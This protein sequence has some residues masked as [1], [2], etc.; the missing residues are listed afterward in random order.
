MNLTQV[1]MYARVSSEQQAETHTIASQVAALRERVAADGLA[2]SE[3]M[4][5]LDE[6]YSGATLVRPALERLRDVIAAGSV[7][8]LY[9]HSP[10]RL[11]RKYAYQVLLVD[12]FRRA[13]VEVVFLNRALGQSPEDDLLLQVQGMIAE[14]ERAK[15]IE[16]HR[17]GK[18]HAA[19]IGTVN[20]LSGAP[21]G[22]R[23]V[24]KYEGGGQARYEIV[25][26]EARVV[27]QVFAWVGHD[28]LTIGEVCRR[29][30]QAGE[31][32]R[33]GKT[34]WDRS[35]VW[36]ILKNPAYQGGAAFGKTRLEPLRPRLRAQR[37]RPVQPRRAVSVRDVPPEDWITIPVPA[38]VEPAV[39]AAVQEQ[40]QENKRHARQ[41]SRRGALYLLQG[42]LQCQHCGYAFY[43]KRLSP[44]AR[45]GK[46]RAYAYYRCL[47]TDAYRFGGERLCQNT[48]VRTDL[49]DLAV[50]QEVCTLLAHPERLAEEYRRRLQPETHAKRPSLA[51][52]E[53]HMSQVRQGIAR[54]IDSYAE[55]LIDKHEFEPRITRLRQRLARLEEQRQALADE[56]AL[57]GELQLIIG[58]LEDF[59]A[60]LHGGLE[61]ADWANKRDL[62]LALVK[63]VEV[64]QND[65][66]I[67][68]RIDP[69][70]GDN[71]PEKKSLQL[72]RGRDDA[73]LWYPTVRLVVLPLLD[74]SRV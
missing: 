60:K 25:P 55:S 23:Y 65:V 33:T 6:G 74:I 22:Y 45:K 47:G 27:R 32:T 51:T 38:L 69:Y 1:A 72:C 12:E 3:A 21:Y 10:D 62:I 59:A 67:V 64:A 44:S 30:T 73:A 19:Q 14:Y 11:A 17:R 18:R 56:A 57:H 43:G 31:V 28:R 15:I 5:F 7:D 26:D 70:P 4:Q 34:V 50:W 8:R 46:P 39:F 36:G 61:A 52:V 63:R 68:F 9:V 53:G 54:L 49:L 2:V 66:N 58:R 42:L 71:D 40:L 35:V 41:Q 20:V 16:R 48:Q 13:G 24:T 37:H 29:L